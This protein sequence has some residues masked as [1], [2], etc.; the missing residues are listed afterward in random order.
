MPMTSLGPWLQTRLR[1]LLLAIIT[2]GILHI[3]ATL[4]APRLAGGT[5]YAFL[6]RV[7]PDGAGW[8]NAGTSRSTV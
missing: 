4:A 6:L 7:M 1:V 5:P 2:A 8:T 3:V